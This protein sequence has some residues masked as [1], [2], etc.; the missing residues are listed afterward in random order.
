MRTADTTAAGPV[1]HQGARVDIT[2]RPAAALNGWLGVLVLAAC[3]AGIVLAAQHRHGLLWLPILVFVV[4]ALSLV[5]VPPGQTSVVQFFGRYVGT[6]G[7]SGFWWVL[8]LTVRRRVSVRVRN[9]ETNRLKVNDA[10]GN[11][12]EIAAIVVWQVVDTAK[13]TYA[14]ENSVDFVSVQAES[15]LRHVATS[16]PYDDTTG[17]GTSLRGST[18]IVAAELAREV[19]ARVAV[20]GVEIVEVRVSHLAYASEIAQAMLRRQQANAVVAA[21]ARIVE[22]AVGMV[23]MALDRLTQDGV[24]SLDEER[25]A[26]MVSNLMVVLCGDQPPAPVVNAGTLYT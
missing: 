15:A 4:V 1:G 5:V 13:A 22:G 12:V 3:V 19:A 11:P 23:E 17:V 21:R 16:H 7:R 20:A 18:D 26:S 8:P 6:V 9:F 14:V 24:V 2:Q 25:T 10:D